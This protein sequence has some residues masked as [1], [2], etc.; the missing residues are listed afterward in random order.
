MMMTCFERGEK[1]Y[2]AKNFVNLHNHSHHGSLLDGFS[3]NDEY[4]SRAVEL[5]Q[6]GL[7]MTD[8]GTMFG[9]YNFLKK[10][11]EY[12]ITGIAGV[13]FYVAP[14]NPEGAQ[15][16]EPV[17]YSTTGTPGRYDVSSRG[18]YLHLTV[19]AYNNV[20]L[21]NLFKLSA[22]SNDPSRVYKKPRI[23]FDLLVEHSDG[24]IVS[25]GCPSSEI[26]T[27]FMLGQDDKAYEYAGRLKEVFGDRLF[28][29]IMNHDMKISLER[30]LLPKQLKLS[31]DLDIPLLATN[32]SHYAHQH[33]NISHEEM[34]CAQSGSRMSEDPI[35]DGGTRFAFSG[36]QYYL[37]SYD[38]MASM[39]PEQDFPGALSNS[40]VI[41]E[42]SQD[43]TLDYDASL[44]AKPVLPAG[45]N[46]SDE[47]YKHLLKVGM[48]DRYQHKSAEIKK[49]A[50]RRSKNEYQVIHSSN[51]IDY[52]LVV[53][54][55]LQWTKDNYSVKD[56]M[57]RI[58]A[59]PL[60]P[61]RGSVAGS[62]HAYMLGISEVCPIEHDLIFERFLGPGRGATY[63]ITYDDGSVEEIVVSEEKTVINNE[64]LMSQKYI[65]QLRVGDL[66]DEKPE[67][68]VIDGDTV[69]SDSSVDSSSSKNVVDADND[70]KNNSNK[71][72]VLDNETDDSD[73]VID[74]NL[75]EIEDF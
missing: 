38:E 11:Q 36:N 56:A 41:A 46:T 42:M 55:Y 40:L 27:R 32:D 52:M 54:N 6:P 72:V 58:L 5:G 26:S 59:S 7:G 45:F 39:F 68:M 57:G 62:I 2:M 24:L 48:K 25:T 69:E 43:I 30:E 33:D 31:K 73:E 65:H 71:T 37:K 75:E 22:L 21:H 49:E 15:R 51:F 50:I 70:P 63:K 64:G 60:G 53:R 34:L 16:L 35:D 19:W 47:Y 66:V 17:Y 14:I 8:H 29:E 28:V 1:K 18:A 3:T 12:S 10:A 20:G 67:D 9:A 61:G 13:E 44:M 23:D 74:T 4:F